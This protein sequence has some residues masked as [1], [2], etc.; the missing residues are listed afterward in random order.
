M[1]M[2]LFERIY[3]NNMIFIRKKKYDM[4]IIYFQ[5]TFIDSSG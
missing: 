3:K 5:L 4:L 1:N 2:R